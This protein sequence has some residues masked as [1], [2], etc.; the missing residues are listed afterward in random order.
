MEMKLS[1]SDEVFDEVVR[2][3]VAVASP[4]RIVL[5]GSGARGRMGKD[6]DL[7]LLVIKS[8]VHRRRLAQ[9]IY[10]G[11]I[12]VGRSVDVVVVTPEDIERFGDSPALI[13]EAA[14]REG[15]EVYGSALDESMRWVSSSRS[16]PCEIRKYRTNSFGVS[17]PCPSAMFAGIAAEARRTC[18]AIP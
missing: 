1:L 18:E 17:R 15:V 8:G 7:D 14:L 16:E 3:I 6:G 10:G 2:R 11:L 13:I 12:G 5:F 9:E 4:E